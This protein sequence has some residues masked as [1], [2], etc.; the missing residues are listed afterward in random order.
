MA[1]FVQLAN[2]AGNTML[3]DILVSTRAQLA[4]YKVPEWLKIVR[5]IPR[6]ALGKIDRKSLPAMLSDAKAGETVATL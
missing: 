4:D 6:N 1:G 5:E 3:D 2:N